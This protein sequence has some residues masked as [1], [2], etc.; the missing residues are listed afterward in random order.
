MK[1]QFA[2]LKILVDEK[3]DSISSFPSQD[4]TDKCSNC[5]SHSNASAN[6]YPNNA[7]TSRFDKN[8]SLIIDGIVEFPNENLKALSLH[9]INEMGV[10]LVPDDIVNVFRL[11]KPDRSRARPRPVKL[12]L[13]DALIRDQI[14]H[15]KTRLRKSKLFSTFKLSLDQEKDVRVRQGILK[16]A[17]NTA[18]AMGLEVFSSP[19]QI[20]I[21]GVEY[22]SM[23]VDKIPPI[24]L[25]DENPTI[26]LEPLNVRRLTIFEKCRKIAENAIK[27]GTSMQKTSLGL[28]FFSAGCFLSNFY[29]CTVNHKGI[30]Y[31]SVKH[32]D[33][34]TKAKICHAPGIHACILSVDSPA[35]AKIYAKE[36]FVTDEW[37]RIKLDIMRELLF[38]KYRQN[39]DMYFK[40]LNTRPHNLLE[41]TLDDY[42]GTGCR[43]LSIAAVEGSWTGQNMLGKLLVE[44][45]D[46]LLLEFES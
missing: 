8:R 20:R 17:A 35:L 1:Q 24:Y 39:R 2:E 38:C 4:S 16:R 41:C 13:K 14:Y 21:D 11:E 6:A 18:R 31:K 43:L 23:N 36:I 34:G 7:D 9:F 42:W 44:V 37:E 22:D 3:N 10:K 27:I 12:V 25:P 28:G 32:G 40:L 45:R 15:F 26:P 33:Q 46:I 29:K 19:N 30:A 5:S